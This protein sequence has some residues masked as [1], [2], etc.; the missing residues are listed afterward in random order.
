MLREKSC[1]CSFSRFK[2]LKK[3]GK[4]QLF[5]FNLL[6]KLISRYSQPNCL[7]DCKC[8]REHRLVS[9]MQVVE[10]TAN[11]QIFILHKLL[12]RRYNC[13][14]SRARLSQ[15]KSCFITRFTMLRYSSVFSHNA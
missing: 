4:R 9:L 12:I 8:L 13:S 7:T 6:H 15:E 10:G 1:K 2:W 14:Y 3:V 5:T 11:S